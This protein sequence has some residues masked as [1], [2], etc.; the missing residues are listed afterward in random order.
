M[1]LPVGM[2]AA[3]REATQATEATRRVTGAAGMV[4]G[5][6]RSVYVLCWGRDRWGQWG[7][8]GGRVYSGQAASGVYR[9]GFGHMPRVLLCLATLCPR[10]SPPAL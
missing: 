3:A 5:G 8:R 1:H 4:A 10:A 6:R 2:K 9:Y 7:K